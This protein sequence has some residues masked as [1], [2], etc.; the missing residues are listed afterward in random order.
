MY[1]CRAPKNQA[2]FDG[3]YQLRWQILRSPWQQ[4]LGSEQ[5]DLEGQS[6]HRV[7]VDDIDNV[8]GVGRMHKCSQD[9][10]QVRYMAIDDSAQGKGLG[11]LL[12]NVGSQ[13]VIS[14]CP[15]K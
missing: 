13:L 9:T 12:L 2:E 11:K 1:Q 10:A 6:Y 5:D 15:S 8:V 7:I 4:P 14:S 3:Y